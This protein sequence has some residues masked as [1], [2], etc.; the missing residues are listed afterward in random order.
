MTMILLFAVGLCWLFGSLLG[1]GEGGNGGTAVLEEALAETEKSLKSIGGRLETLCKSD[2]DHKKRFD[3]VETRYKAVAADLETTR[4]TLSDHMEAMR[5]AL[6]AFPGVHGG[7]FDMP[8]EMWETRGD[9]SGFRF[10]DIRAAK[11]FGLYIMAHCSGD[12]HERDIAMKAL[13]KGQ[14]ERWTGAAFKA[15]SGNNFTAGGAIVPDA[16][17]PDII[18]NVEMHGHFQ[19]NAGRI[20]MPAPTV[21]IPKDTGELTIY[22]PEDNVAIT[23]SDPSLGDVTLNARLYATLTKWPNSLTEDSAI[24]LAAWLA[25]KIA[26]IHAKHRDL[27]GFLGDGTSTYAR[28]TGA[29][30]APNIVTHILGNAV[31]ASVTSTGKTTFG[32]LAYNDLVAAQALLPTKARPDAKWYCHR[33][34]AGIMRSLVDTNGRPIFE[35]DYVNGKRC[36]RI[37]GDP[38]VEVDVLPSTT[39]TATDFI[40]YGSLRLGMGFGER[41]S[42]A[43]ANSREAGFSADQTWIRSTARVAISPLDGSQMIRLRTSTT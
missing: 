5:A 27:N 11:A 43:I 4:K 36:T 34:V 7:G 35:T 1:I 6:K 24:D 39:G 30:N 26:W 19:V 12:P 8:P 31:G 2:D 10:S 13:D 23:D 22:Y 17:I 28:V 15:L 33:F 40:L 42:L 3:D 25:E 18:R 20:P 21:T 37:L 9:G 16:F 41:R 38:L 14:N 29:F 32:S